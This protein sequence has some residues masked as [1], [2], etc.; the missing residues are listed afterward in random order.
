MQVV[1][2][3][4]RGLPAHCWLGMHGAG[5]GVRQTGSCG[6]SRGAGGS[7]DGHRLHLP[8]RLRDAGQGGQATEGQVPQQA[9][10]TCDLS[11]SLQALCDVFYSKELRR[12]S[13]AV[14]SATCLSNCGCL[15][16][17]Y[18][19]E[20]LACSLLTRHMHVQA[21][22]STCCQSPKKCR[23]AVGQLHYRDLWLKLSQTLCCGATL[24]SL[25]GYKPFTTLRSLPGS[26][27]AA[28]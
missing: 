14:L 20:A 28:D 19:L 2:V 6:V 11:A 23:G 8:A 17:V 4:A 27:A 1:R 15:T 18:M 7:C 21:A 13:I 10:L 9:V 16:F 25:L 3:M 22:S 24:R 26:Q 5:E 12:S